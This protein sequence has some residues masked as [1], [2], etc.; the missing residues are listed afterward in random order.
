MKRDCVNIV[1]LREMKIQENKIVLSRIEEGKNIHKRARVKLSAFLLNRKSNRT[2]Y[3]RAYSSFGCSARM[4]TWLKH[5][6]SRDF[7]NLV[8][9][10]ATG[11]KLYIHHQNRVLFPTRRVAARHT[12]LPA[13]RALARHF[14]L[15]RWFMKHGG[16]TKHNETLTLHTL[17]GPSLCLFLSLSRPLVDCPRDAAA[18]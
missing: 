12:A 6:A 14:C 11:I 10:R 5:S 2:F 4:W 8:C 15:F 1:C 13:T 18:K 7:A 9:A 16:D 17:R 3:F